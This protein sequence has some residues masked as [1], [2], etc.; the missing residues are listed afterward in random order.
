MNKLAAEKRIKK[1]KEQLGE[2]DRAYYVLD[3]PIVSDAVRDSLKDELE[4]L[5]KE[6]PGLITPDS[7]TQR[8]GGK[9]LGKF[10]KYRHRVPKYSF[11]D[12]FS[13][14]EV[15]EFDQRIKRFLGLPSGQ[16]VE[17]ICELKIDGLNMSFIYE[18]GLLV[19]A[20][21]R[22][23]GVTGE[24]VTH[25]VR[26]IGSVP[27]KL[28]EALNIEVGG[29]VYM[30]KKSFD[31]LNQQNKKN[32]LPLF[33][34][35]RNAAAGSVRQLDPKVA[36]QRDLDSFMWT[37]YEPQ[38][39]GL[40][41]H[42]EIMKKMAGL[43]LKVN[44]HWKKVKN[45][46]GTLAYF[47]HWEKYRES[48]PFEID[49]IVIKVNDLGWQERLGRTAKQ[50]RWAAAY[51]FPA[52][53]VTTVVKDIKIQVGRTGALTPVAHLRP[54]S[55]AGSLVKRATLHNQDE[56]QR[57]DIKIGDTVVLQKAGD[58]IPEVVKVLPKLRTGKEKKFVM[59]ASCPIC[60]SKVIRKAGEVAYYCTNK[61]CFAQQQERLNHF[62]SKTAFNI[63][64][65][66]PKILE[67][68]QRADLVKTA[69]DLFL[70]REDDLKPLERFA[71]KSADNLVRSLNDSKKISLAKFIYALGIRHVGEETAILLADYFGSWEK[72]SSAEAEE[73]EKVEGTGPK[74]AASI[75]EWLTSKKNNILAEQLLKRGVRIV[76][77]ASKVSAK[78]KNTTFVL[79]GELDSLTRDEAKEK[80]RKSGGDV[81]ASVSL[82]TDYVVAGA[83]PGSK[84]TKAEKLKVKIISEK[85]F[86][87]LLS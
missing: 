11:D 68:L 5:E 58:I 74:V 56:I 40:K 34:N 54:V 42:E 77:S 82:K 80:I 71:E 10:E 31:K 53:Q 41:K 73:L 26:T 39:F 27:L 50:V 44:G 47:K 62:V 55:L 29:E 64:G 38:Y 37:I 4:E 17:Y 59:P 65:L 28:T 7:P 30:P 63:D 72:L 21:T 3:K 32:K 6:F 15:E 45:I 75:R 66:G 2:I 86:L 33:A 52:D 81:S 16:E 49:G 79:T 35:P 87:K 46:K 70:L 25:T 84:Y 61:D 20:V 69:A 67:Q 60:G 13:F 57:L 22:G 9:A 76:N 36:A 19:R 14:E 85:E 51:K 48:L 23:D 12:V 83:N 24:V 1:L 8:I 43:G 78:L 18:K